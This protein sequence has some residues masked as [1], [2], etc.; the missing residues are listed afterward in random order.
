MELL[1]PGID[2]SNP[3]NVLGPPP[4]FGILT[5]QTMYKWMTMI[6][7]SGNILLY[8]SSAQRSF[9]N[10]INETVSCGVLF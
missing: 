2:F 8:N 1:H 4:H 3:A 5:H 9:Y 6:L 7:F 10:P